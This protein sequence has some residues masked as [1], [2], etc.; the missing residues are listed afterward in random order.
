MILA[1]EIL[2]GWTLLSIIA[3]PIVAPWLKR[4]FSGERRA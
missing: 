3:A 1:L 4:R 2:A